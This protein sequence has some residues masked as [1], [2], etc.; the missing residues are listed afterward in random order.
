MIKARKIMAETFRLSYGDIVDNLTMEEVDTWDSLVHMELVANLES[1]LGL[2]F[3]GDEIVEM[4]SVDA[5][6]KLIEAKQG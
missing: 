4:T 2:E 1:G 3:T 5:I 6:I